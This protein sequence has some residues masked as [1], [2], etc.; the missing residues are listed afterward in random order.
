MTTTE[1]LLNDDGEYEP[2]PVEWEPRSIVNN[3][4]DH[5]IDD[6]NQKFIELFSNNQPTGIADKPSFLTSQAVYNWLKNLNHKADHV[7]DRKMDNI[8]KRLPKK[9]PSQRHLGQ[10]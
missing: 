3:V 6:I 7:Q 2:E 4:V 1:L 10:S 8:L 9:K 5:I